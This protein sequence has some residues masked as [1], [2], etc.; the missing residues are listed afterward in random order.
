MSISMIS[1]FI[2][3]KIIIYVEEKEEEE[4]KKNCLHF[5][6]TNTHIYIFLSFSCFFFFS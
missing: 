3:K 6:S 1:L 5:P 4:E 2:E